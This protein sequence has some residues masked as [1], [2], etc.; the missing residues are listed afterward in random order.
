VANTTCCFVKHYKYRIQS[1]LQSLAILLW[2]FSI[3]LHF[4]VVEFQCLTGCG[5]PV[6]CILWNSSVS[7]GCGIPV[8]HRLWNPS[9]SQVVEFQ[10]LTWLWNPSV[11][12][13]VESQCL[14][15]LWN[16]SVSQVV[17]FHRLQSLWNSNVSHC[18]NLRF[19]YFMA[20]WYFSVS[21]GCGIPVSH[22]VVV[23]M[24]LTRLWYFSI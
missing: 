7:H 2:Y 9:I 18:Y 1:R 5:L 16:S 6:S 20:I 22:M 23:F 12:Q 15:W 8:S 14:P 24:C 3:I 21:H 13:V 10:Y 4:T 19:Q 17:D 11:S